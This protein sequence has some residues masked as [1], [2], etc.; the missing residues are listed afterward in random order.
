MGSLIEIDSGNSY[1]QGINGTPYTT[2]V[3]IAESGKPDVDFEKGVT[4]AGLPVGDFFAKN[5]AP[6][7]EDIKLVDAIAPK[8]ADITINTPSQDNNISSQSL[9]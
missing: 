9:G 4:V 2:Q 7:T 8:T 3:I 6:A 5:A 1:Q